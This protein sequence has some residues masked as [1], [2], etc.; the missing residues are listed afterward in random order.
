MWETTA[1]EAARGS[2]EARKE[3]RRLRLH[4]LFPGQQLCDAELR[5]LPS[6]VKL[7]GSAVKYIYIIIILYTLLSLR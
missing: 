4:I 2:P 5:F 6:P 3:I 7:F 1:A